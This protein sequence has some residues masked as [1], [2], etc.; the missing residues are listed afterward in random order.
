MDETL[1]TYRENRDEALVAYLYGEGDPAEQTAFRAHLAVCRVCRAELAGFER[2]RTQLAGWTPP[3][4]ARLPAFQATSGPPRRA[5]FLAI[6]AE[7]PAW[8]QLAAA[9]LFI[10]IAAGAANLNVRYDQNGLSIRTGWSR[11]AT[12]EMSASTTPVPTA[13]PQSP[14]PWRAEITALEQRLRAE[15]RP[16]TTTSAPPASMSVSDDVIRRMQTLIDQSERRQQRELALRVGQ[17]LRDV[18]AQRQAD[19]VRIDRT[20]GFIQTDTG[21]EVLRQ[22]RLLNDLAVQVSQRQTPP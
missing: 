10:G 14:V 20:L 21:A 9:T 4:P 18:Q 22:R 2:V 12:A 3:E 15:L 5:R 17:L 19:L 7:I 6:L 8:A 16:A 1:C 13:G 11:P